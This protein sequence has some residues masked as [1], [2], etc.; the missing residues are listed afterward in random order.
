MFH[1]KFMHLT[2]KSRNV[3]ILFSLLSLIEGVLWYFLPI[4][5][6]SQLNSLFLI[7]MLMAAHP[8]ASLFADLPA[9]DLCDKIGRKFAFII[10]AIGFLASFLL[11]Y[12]DNF[13]GFLFFMLIYGAFSTLYSVSANTAIIDYS[14]RNH[15]GEVNGIFVSLVY[16]GWFAGSVI[17]GILGS[18]FIQVTLFNI[19][20]IALLLVTL[21]A[22][23]YF[24]GKTMPK[25][26]SMRKAG[27][28]LIRDHLWFGEF[29]SI[30]KINISIIPAL[31]FYFIWGFWEY[32]IWTFEPIYTN[33]VVGSDFFV[34]AIILGLLSLPTI[35]IAPLGG[36]LT[37]KINPRK[38]IFYGAVLL[39]IG[40]SIFLMIQD[41]IG[42]TLSLIIT[43]I[44]ICFISLP[45][46]YIEKVQVKQN[47][48]G[49]V[50]G[51]EE[52]LYNIGGILG[53]LSVGTLFTITNMSHLFYLTFSL[54]LISV[55]LL[56]PWSRKVFK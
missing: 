42:L 26:H 48:R 34:G 36:W 50:V 24:P 3:I 30:K 47:F 16:F 23:L 55:V 14:N 43:S 13:I 5:F 29:G 9:G 51:Y 54:F 25:K 22:I 32:A 46:C 31:F 45:I 27:R 41:L 38:M 53:P 20:A 2:N 35:L 52:M 49:E 37:D 12:T 4:Y 11:L 39:I 21:G 28:I 19:L 40:Q 56:I 8:L 6:E 18:I 15:V 1:S 10:G 7:G 33:V 17:A 44:G